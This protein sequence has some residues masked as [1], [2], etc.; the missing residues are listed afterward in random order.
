MQRQSRLSGRG[1]RSLR[2]LLKNIARAR[3]F[4]LLRFRLLTFGLYEPHPLYGRRV[5]THPRWQMNP[6]VAWLLLRHTTSYGRWLV[7]MET[8][9]RDG[10]AGW[11]EYQAGPEGASRLR[12]WMDAEN[13]F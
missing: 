2:A 12:E 6:R 13:S 9:A 8:V 1:Q 5:F 4:R 3:R 11:W 10:A 7:E